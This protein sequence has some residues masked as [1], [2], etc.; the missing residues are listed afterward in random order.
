MLARQV[1]YHLSRSTSPTTANFESIQFLTNIKYCRALYCFEFY[2]W[3]E[4][5][6]VTYNELF[7][8]CT[9]HQVLLV[10]MSQQYLR[11][12]RF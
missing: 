8:I 5:V 3:S 7:Q 11:I 12:C 10:M 4:V 2:A 6:L 9:I 1:I